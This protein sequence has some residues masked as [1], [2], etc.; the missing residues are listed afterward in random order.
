MTTVF[1][2]TTFYYK[3]HYH[4]GAHGRSQGLS[5]DMVGSNEDIKFAPLQRETRQ[6]TRQDHII[7]LLLLD[8]V[9]G[10]ALPVVVVGDAVVVVVVLG[11]TISASHYTSKSPVLSLSH[12]TIPGLSNISHLTSHHPAPHLSPLK[13]R[14][15]QDHQRREVEDNSLLYC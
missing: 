11:L 13:T 3:S 2:L 7:P 8:V 1:V 15:Q 12:F 6:E 4:G 10:L 9:L 14:S 5:H